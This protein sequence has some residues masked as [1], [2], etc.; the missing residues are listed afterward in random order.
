[1]SFILSSNVSSTHLR[2][3]GDFF[4][5]AVGAYQGCLL[6]PVQFN[7]FLEKIMQETS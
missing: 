7:L 4:R 1:M 6:S 3:A 5:R 2:L